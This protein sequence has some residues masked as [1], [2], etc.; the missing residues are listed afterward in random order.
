MRMQDFESIEWCFRAQMNLSIHAKSFGSSSTHSRSIRQWY[1]LKRLKHGP[2]ML[3]LNVDSKVSVGRKIGVV[4]FSMCRMRT[5]TMIAQIG[6]TIA[7][8]STYFPLPAY[9]H[10]PMI[11]SNPL[12]LEVSF[13][14]VAVVAKI[15]NIS[16]RP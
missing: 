3:A 7:T 10:F 15:R 6:A 12:P 14:V 5:M 4:T 8:Q 2:M 13:V 16:P 1:N 9:Y 11:N